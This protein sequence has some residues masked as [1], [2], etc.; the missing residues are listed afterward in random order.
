MSRLRQTI[1]GLA[2]L[3]VFSLH[4]QNLTPSIGQRS[5]T[6]NLPPLPPSLPPSPVNY[7]RQLLAMPT[8]ERNRALTNRPPDARARILAK[9]QEY[10]ALAPDEREL[11]LRATELRWY[12]TPLF[13]ADSDERE[14]R[15]TQVPEDLRVIVKSRLAQWDLLPPP[16][17]KEFLE[18]DRAKNYFARVDTTNTAT[19]DPDRQKIS[20]Q[21]NQFFE[22]TSEEKTQMLGTLSEAERAQM[23]KTLQSFEQMPP[24]QRHQCVKNFTRFAGMTAAERAEFLQN[25]E[26]WSKMSPQERQ[27]WRDLV[28]HVPQWPPLPPPAVP[29]NLI[30][31][32]PIKAPHS[33][34]ATN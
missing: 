18:N 28:S 20:E 17:Q 2:A 34:M 31:R 9:V 19:M 23:E 24:Q 21:F 4:A 11:R 12:L 30:P 22:L 27:S 16:L 13:R 15:F 29:A 32:V 5:S 33:G 25:A 3:V 6:T 1:F 14:A 7:F 8:S 26:R 10:L